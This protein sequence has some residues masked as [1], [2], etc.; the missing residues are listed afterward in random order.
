LA[1]GAPFTLAA[2]IQYGF[3]F[4]LRIFLLRLAS[5]EALG[6]YGLAERVQVPMNLAVTAAGR[7]WLPWLLTARPARQ[8][9]VSGAVSELSGLVLLV[10]GG[11]VIFLNEILSLFG[12]RYEG[13]YPAGIL[14][15]IAGWIYFVGDW[16]VSGTLSLTGR[17]GHRIW[18]FSL[19]YGV[20]AIVAL[21]VVGRWGST[22]A[23]AAV[24]VA[25]VLILLGMVLA[26]HALHPLGHGLRRLLPLS[27]A[28]IALAVCASATALPWFKIVVAL[29]YGALLWRAGLLRR[30]TAAGASA[31]LAVAKAAG[32]P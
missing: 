12:G 14:L 30:W 20:A 31:P 13:A 21:V 3:S 7:A 18:V 24:L 26:G 25:C 16:I 1:F 8:A 2:V 29:G 9:V 32:S 11:M 19:A 6:W 23:A 22:G 17:T 15:L 4:L 27:A 5:A 10:L 28:L